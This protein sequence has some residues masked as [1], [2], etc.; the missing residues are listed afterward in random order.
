MSFQ[1]FH[2][3]RPMW[4]LALLPLLLILIWQYRSLKERNAWHLVCDPNL[5]RFLLKGKGARSLAPT[6]WLAIVWLLTV[7]A[8]AGPC[9]KQLSV[10]L[11]KNQEANVILFDN[12]Y[13]MDASD[14]PPSRLMIARYKLLDLVRLSRDGRFGLIAYSGEPYVASPLTD[15]VKTL[16]NFVSQLSP[17]MMPVT[18]Y[19]LDK[20]LSL[21]ATL[22]K[23]S[24]EPSGNI[25]V[26]TGNNATKNDIDTAKQLAKEGY[27]TFVLGIGSN[28]GGPILLPT[29]RYLKN[30]QGDIL[31]AKLD[32]RTLNALATAGHGLYM[33]H[34]NSDQDIRQ[35]ITAAHGIN[36]SKSRH[37][38]KQTVAEWQDEGRW[39]LLFILPLLLLGFYRGW[40][41]G[42]LA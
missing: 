6:L 15:D 35:L 20:A 33:A 25:F 30:P 9:W 36:I 41:V 24:G 14:V 2:L 21:A 3:L 8:L 10:P 31:I 29:G 19:Q 4:L 42:Y 13:I 5:L 12:S 40:L 38:G 37:H 27:K 7:L 17:N 34:T 32:G 11:L 22:L 28:K 16:E 39:F 1:Y 23:Q 26:F 18:G